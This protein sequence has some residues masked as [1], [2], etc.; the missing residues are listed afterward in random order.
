MYKAVDFHL[1][2]LRFV[3]DS[4]FTN[5]MIEK[6]DSAAFSHDYIVFGDLDSNFLTI[7]VNNVGLISIYLFDINL[8]G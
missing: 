4:F 2:A 5:N 3:S 8:D 1:L 6:L 7:F